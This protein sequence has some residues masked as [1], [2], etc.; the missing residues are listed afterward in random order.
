ML[1]SP[2]SR[3]LL[4][5]TATRLL[6]DGNTTDMMHLNFAKA[7]DA[8]NHSFLLEKLESKKCEKSSDGSNPA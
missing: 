3:L 4:E 8:V 2:Q 7:F 6:K 5:E 1:L